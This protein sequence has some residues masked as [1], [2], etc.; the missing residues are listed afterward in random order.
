MK[1]WKKKRDG[2]SLTQ[3]SSFIMFVL[4]NK[5]RRKEKEKKT[6]SGYSQSRKQTGDSFFWKTKLIGCCT[7]EKEKKKYY[8]LKK[9]KIEK[10]IQKKKILQDDFC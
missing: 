4:D 8:Y 1:S 3:S 2:E 6:F 9:K 5:E 10:E 7:I